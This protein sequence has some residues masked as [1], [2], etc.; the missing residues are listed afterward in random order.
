MSLRARVFEK[1]HIPLI[2][3][4]PLARRFWECSG[5]TLVLR[6]Q[7]TR[8]PVFAEQDLT[9]ADSVIMPEAGRC[10]TYLKICLATRNRIP[11]L[12]LEIRLRRR[13]VTSV[14]T[15]KHPYRRHYGRGCRCAPQGF[16]LKG[17]YFVCW[18]G[19]QRDLCPLLPRSR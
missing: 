9:L 7:Q 1:A 2:I 19:D 15:E 12:P 13:S 17:A 6:S 10:L 4:G 11:F 16:Y 5:W 8:D 3:G 14:I 18:R